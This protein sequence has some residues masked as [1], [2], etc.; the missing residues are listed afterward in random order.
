M[1]PN[2]PLTTQPFTQAVWAIA[3]GVAAPWLIILPAWWAW[4][5]YQDRKASREAQ[6]RLQRW[7]ATHPL[8]PEDEWA[9]LAQIKDC[10]WLES[11]SPDTR[12]YILRQRQE[13]AERE[14]RARTILDAERR[15]A[16]DGETRPQEDPDENR[17]L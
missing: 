11:L 10:L 5:R 9:R 2:A 14:A 13:E 4:E 3:L 7:E 1:D 15:A 16:R 6:E 8:E 12:R 17:V